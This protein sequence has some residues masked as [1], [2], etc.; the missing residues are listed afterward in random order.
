MSFP[1]EK[2][3][4]IHN[5]DEMVKAFENGQLSGGG[6]SFIHTTQ[7]YKCLVHEFINIISIFQYFDS[8]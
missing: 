2:I 1:V 3:T 7:S 4:V 6:A 8:K 5:G